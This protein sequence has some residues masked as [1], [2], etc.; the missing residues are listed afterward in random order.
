MKK[1]K[2]TE[3]IEK[4]VEAVLPARHR[5]NNNFSPSNGLLVED[6]FLS[7]FERMTKPPLLS[8]PRPF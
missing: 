1:K 2:N 6:K 4:K 3:I 7:I 5:G 8:K